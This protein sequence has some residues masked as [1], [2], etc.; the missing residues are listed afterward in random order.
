MST[1]K[2]RLAA[3][4]FAD[5]AGYSRLIA[6]NDVEAVRRWRDLRSEIIEPL[7]LR[8]GGKVAEIAGDAL[9]VEFASVVDAVRWAAEL[10]RMQHARHDASDPFSLEL[11]IGVNVDDIIDDDGVLQGDGVNVASRI[12]QAAGR[13]QIAVTSRVRE[14]VTNRLPL[15]FTDMGTPPMK[16]IAQPVR[17]FLV[18][19]LGSDGMQR[20]P[21]PYLQWS[22][23]PTVAVLPFRNA[24][25]GDEDAYFGEGI[26]D[27]I[28]TGLSRSRSMYVIARNSTLRYRGRG[29]QDL[30][31]IAGELDV[32]FLL[33]GSV[34]RQGAR[35]RIR[36]ELLDITGDRSVWSQR[37]DG[38]NEEVFDFQDRIAARI[39]AS[40]EP[41]VRAVETARAGAWPTESLDAYDCVLKAMSRLYRFTDE[42]YAEAQQ[43][44]DRALQLDGGYAQAHAYTAWALVFV[45][46]E[47]RSADPAFDRRRALAA[48]HRALELDPEDP[49]VLCIAAH[50]HGFLAKELDH[51]ND[52]FDR[53]LALDENS[54]FVWG[55]SALTKAYLGQSEEALERL[56]NLWRLNPYDPLNFYFWIVAGIAEF[57]AGRYDEAVAWTRKSSRANP[58]FIAAQRTLAASL[59][60]SGDTAGA[61]EVARDLLA[62]EPTFRVSTFIE[63][64]PLRRPEDLQRLA[65]GLRAA[66][67]P[68]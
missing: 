5:V 4:A 2:R 19:W 60:L 42:S 40:L 53:A 6:T 12:H 21:Q 8:H 41:S 48:S 52:L 39:I 54:A 33:D 35:L 64:Y 43:L 30:R 49:F 22:S 31:Q 59:A 66:G 9:L 32:R 56:Q 63:W 3:I 36:V 44:L 47:G 45:L 68:A 55:L 51:A 14:F 62:I 29:D 7:L 65:D 67:L 28:I 26:T 37:F 25:A 23:R 61:H 11:R 57:V 34:W 18:D 16:N 50:V 1:L 27:E 10:Q 24:A 46:G 38:G 15:K 17:V 58:R 13:G 20:V